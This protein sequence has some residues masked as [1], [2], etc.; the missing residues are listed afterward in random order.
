ME[1]GAP[2][3]YRRSCGERRTLTV[4]QPSVEIEQAVTEVWSQVSDETG[5]APHQPDQSGLSRS[6]GGSGPERRDSLVFQ[7]N[8]GA[9]LNL[10]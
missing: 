1:A 3:G 7:Y 2:A 8:S 4:T 10:R 6:G 5:K 9:F